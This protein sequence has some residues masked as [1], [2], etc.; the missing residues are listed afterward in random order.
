MSILVGETTQIEM[1]EKANAKSSERFNKTWVFDKGGDRE[2]TFVLG[3]SQEHG[4]P[5]DISRI[6][7]S[8][9]ST[10]NPN[11]NPST[12]NI[13]VHERLSYTVLVSS[14]AIS[15]ATISSSVPTVPLVVN[16]A[17]LNDLF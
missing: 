15:R 2:T 12:P 4:E 3:F 10:V 8:G 9:M 11:R 1:Q 16:K 5:T 6:V 14:E 17:A 7:S 13:G